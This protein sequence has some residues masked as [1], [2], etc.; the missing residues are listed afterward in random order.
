MEVASYWQLVMTFLVIKLLNTPSDIE[1]FTVEINHTNRVIISVIYA[2]PQ[3]S[4][5]F[6]NSCCDHLSNLIS[7]SLPII[8]VGDFNLPDINWSILS[9][10]TTISNQFCEYIFDL[11][12]KQLIDQP[13]HIQGNILD[14]VLTNVE[15]L[16][17]FTI[18]NCCPYKVTTT[19][20][21]LKCLLC[22]SLGKAK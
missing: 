21:H 15:H 12:L 2:A 16:F 11:N 6:F 4:T 18:Q 22:Q 10:S 19:P 3:S 17:Q 14:L 1:G 5:D 7:T 9:G 20:L 8:V 13:T